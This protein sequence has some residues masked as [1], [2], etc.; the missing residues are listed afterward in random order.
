[1]RGHQGHQGHCDHDDDNKEDYDNNKVENNDKGI[2][3][4]GLDSDIGFS[5][6]HQGLQDHQPHDDDYNKKDNDNNNDKGISDLEEDRNLV[7][8]PSTSMFI[9]SI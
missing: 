1:M 4:P 8:F 6:G 7:S 9:L 3:A 2:S 5:P